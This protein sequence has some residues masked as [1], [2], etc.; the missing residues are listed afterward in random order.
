MADIDKDIDTIWRELQQL[1]RLPTQQEGTSPRPSLAHSAV[2]T[3]WDTP[4]WRRRDTSLPE[5][6]RGATSRSTSL[7]PATTRSLT[8]R[9]TVRVTNSTA[10]KG[11]ST[12]Q[13]RW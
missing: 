2:R 7:P 5:T 6:S 11:S 13:V 3:V 12:Q 1:D 4:G 8:S 9:T 10:N